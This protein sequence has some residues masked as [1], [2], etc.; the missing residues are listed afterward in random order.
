MEDG[1]KSEVTYEIVGSQEADPSMFRISDDSP[2]GKGL[3]D[4]HKGDIVDIDAPS[5]TLRFEIINI[6]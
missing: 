3:I 2:F 4:R 5:G 1:T 6:E